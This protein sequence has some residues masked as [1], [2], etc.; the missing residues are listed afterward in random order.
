MSESELEALEAG[1]SQWLDL[2][3]AGVEPV[4]TEEP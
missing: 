3:I 4:R 2:L 1:W